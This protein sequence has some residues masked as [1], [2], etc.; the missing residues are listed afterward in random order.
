MKKLMSILVSCLLINL[1]CFAFYDNTTK[2]KMFEVMNQAELPE[3]MQGVDIS[4]RLGAK[5]NLDLEFT[6]QHGQKK[7]LREIFSN[8]KPILIS[9]NY[10]T[11]ST[12]CG[13]QLA[14]LAQTI[15]E[16][17]W[18][19]GKDFNLV[20][21][22]FDPKDTPDLAAKHHKIY[23]TQAGQPNAPW[24]FLVGDE[25]SIKELTDSIGF[26]YKYEPKSKFYSHTSALFFI[27]PVP[28]G[29]ITRYLYGLSY[30]ANDIK[31]ALMDTAADKIGSSV[32]K[33][34]LYCC[35]YDPHAGAYTGLAMG[36]MRVVC[37]AVFIIL[38]TALGIFFW[39]ERKNKTLES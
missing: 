24:H 2:D 9:L 21:I 15:K 6:D 23:A 4:E 37:S 35:N 12:L 20:T 18:P 33:F 16:I 32:D 1:P 26:F 14:N 7:S 36:L 29:K 28:E 34:L 10:Y 5:I 3:I 17:G 31:F 19:I 13:V 38:F 11:C 22:S 8:G 39:R 25:K 30:K 27:S